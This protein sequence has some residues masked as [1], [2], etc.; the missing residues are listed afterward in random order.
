MKNNYKMRTIKPFIFIK[1]LNDNYKK[2]PYNKITST[3]GPTRYF[4]PATQEW[5]N[6]IYTYDKNFIK[7][8]SIA[9]KNLSKLIKSYFNLFFSSKLSHNKR[10]NTRLRR[11]VINK[12]FISKAELKH[13]SSKIIITL[14]MY[15]EEKRI[16]A[17]K[18]KRLETILFA[19]TKN[20]FN[21]CNKS[22]LLSIKEKLNI[23]KYEKENASFKSL[24]DKLRFS[25]V[26]EIELE[27]DILVTIENI[28]KREEKKLHILKLERNL[29]NLTTIIAVC[30]KDLF[31]YKYYKN[32]YSKV[33][34]N[35]FLE[36]EIATITYYKLLLDLN[37][38]K[39]EDKLLFVLKPM[40]S[41]LYNKEIE[42][43]VVNLKAIYL[44]SDIFTQ[45]ISLK[46]KNRNN[47]LLKVLRSFLYTV[48]LPKVNVVK[49]RF[50]YINPRNLWINLVKNLKV[51]NLYFKNL[52]NN[53]DNLDIL[54]SG[55]L[56][57]SNLT[58]ELGIYQKYFNKNE[59]NN[60]AFFNSIFKN[61]KYKDVGGVRLEA[62]GR[63]TKRFT[64]SRS[65][66]KIKWKGS[67][68]NIDSSYRGLSSTVL[69]GHIKSNV[70]YSMINS[71][72]RN[73]AFGLKGWIGGK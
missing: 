59:F 2:I 69:R 62:K 67:L 15:N 22:R 7:N 68:K 57:D 55:V 48:K 66:F 9:D 17:S 5:Y 50:S 8:I 4:P 45:V 14:Y 20:Y 53:K 29:D 42:F 18:I 16:L 70:Q 43:N 60:T 36:R 28:E 10:I 34:K 63:L 52:K 40:I 72:T 37:K 33:V 61:F 11:L 21:E 51:K 35:Y 65:V 32:I 58:K 46:L 26:R 39:F 12:I 49:E 24:L 30:E 47:G 64:A 6:S 27:K 19:S 23:I 56:K 13:T 38:Y 31:L 41:K 25:I 3:L 73:G 44:N 1:N 54:L 71:K